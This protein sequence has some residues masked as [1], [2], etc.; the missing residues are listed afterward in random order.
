MIGYN[1]YTTRIRP[2]LTEPEKSSHVSGLLILLAILIFALGVLRPVT[3]SSYNAYLELQSAKDYD[4]SLS[5]KI[6]A[7]NQAKVNFA[8]ISS[9]LA[10]IE[11]AVPKGISQPELIQELSQDSGQAGAVLH[12]ISFRSAEVFIGVL[13]A[14]IPNLTPLMERL[15]EGRLIS[16]EELQANFQQIEGENLWSINVQGRAINI[17]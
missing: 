11:N 16:L 15:E 2:Y 17:E 6:V 12:S 5:E 8:E 4:K 9:Q 14:P 7:L 3:I 10:E 13:T 1:Y